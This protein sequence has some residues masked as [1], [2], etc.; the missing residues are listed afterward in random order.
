MAVI[1][2]GYLGRQHVRVLSQ[3]ENVDLVGVVDKNFQ[4]AQ[5]V[6][7]EYSTKAY[8]HYETLVGQ[9]SAVSLAV[10]T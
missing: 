6:A 7:E 5:A 8:V 4:T 9:V 1:G 3:L 10:P 2:T